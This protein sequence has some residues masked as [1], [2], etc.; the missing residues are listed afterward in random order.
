MYPRAGKTE[1]LDAMNIQKSLF[2]LIQALN[3]SSICSEVFENFNENT[4]IVALSVLY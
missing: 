1:T 3:V 4:T 2:F